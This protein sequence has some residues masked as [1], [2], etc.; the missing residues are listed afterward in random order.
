M[1]YIFRNFTA[2][3]CEDD[4]SNLKCAPNAMSRR[5]A[6]KVETSCIGGHNSDTTPTTRTINA[7]ADGTRK[8]IVRLIEA[9]RLLFNDWNEIRYDA[10]NV[11]QINF[12]G[13]RSWMAKCSKNQNKFSFRFASPKPFRACI[14]CES[15]YSQPAP[16]VCRNVCR[17]CIATCFLFTKN[18]P[19]INWATDEKKKWNRNTHYS[20]PSAVYSQHAHLQFARNHRNEQEWTSERTN[21]WN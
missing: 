16:T 19:K 2:S 7:D 6:A 12:A 8:K 4:W 10:I 11:M 13:H 18:Q 5:N 17:M 3:L 1:Q 14:R 9:Y 15:A 21:T 20:P